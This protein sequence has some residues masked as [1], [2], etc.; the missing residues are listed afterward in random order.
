MG[1]IALIACQVTYAIIRRV[2]SPSEPARSPTPSS[3]GSYLVTCGLLCLI[4]LSIPPA[5]ASTSGAMNFSVP[6]T[7]EVYSC[8][9]LFCALPAGEVSVECEPQN[10]TK[11]EEYQRHLQ[12]VVYIG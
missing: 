6:T 4:I 7:S 12:G 10:P 3:D 2:Q 1:A 5:R 9:L 8:F 11:S